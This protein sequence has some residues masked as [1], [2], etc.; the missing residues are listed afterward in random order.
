MLNDLSAEHLRGK[1]TRGSRDTVSSDCPPPPLG[2][3]MSAVNVCLLDRNC[4]KRQARLYSERS[5]LREA[6]R[7]VDVSNRPRPLNVA[8]AGP[9]ARVYE[10]E[11]FV[12][13]HLKSIADAFLTSVSGPRQGGDI[14]R[15]AG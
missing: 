3:S 9:N 5:H 13:L 15:S 14:L 2:E 4:S 12:D 11:H 8:R 6:Q 7:R 1:V 10:V